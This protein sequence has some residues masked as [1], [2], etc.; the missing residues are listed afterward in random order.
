MTAAL[1]MIASAAAAQEIVPGVSVDGFK[2]ERNGNY[3]AVDMTLDLSGLKVRRNRAVLLTPCVINPDDSLHLKSVGVYGRRRYYYYVRNFGEEM[4]S[5]ADE[6][7]YRKRDMPSTLEYHDIV[8]YEGWMDGAELQLHRYLYGCCNEILDVETGRLG[9][10]VAFVPE[11]LY[12]TP[13]AEV[14]ARTLEGSAYVDFVVD[15]TDIRPDYHD[16]EAELGR[17]RA[18]I[19]SVH[20]DGDI[21]I[22]N[23]WLKGYAS[24]ESPYKHNSDLARGR[25]EAVKRHVQDLCDIPGEKITTEY[26]PE[27]WE[28][29]RRFVEQSGLEHRD[30]ILELIDTDMDPDAKEAQ[31]RRAYPAEYR[32]LLQEC[33]PYLR[34]TDYRV[35]YTVRGY[36]DVDEIRRILYTEPQKLNLNEMYLVA[37]TLEP[38]SDEFVEVFQI[39]VRMY[40]EDATANLNAANVEMRHGEYAAAERNLAKA[41]D[42]AEAEYARGVWCYLTDDREAARGH[43]E[44]AARAGIEQASRLLREME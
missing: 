44:T 43:L 5:G 3:M 23:I 26:E 13:R 22:D 10:Y 12:V 30:G 38:G 29:L 21:T 17:I 16:N 34:R 14:K 37:Q 41:G 2:A 7:T 9:T 20:G 1:C 35:N 36:S 28:G 40:P 19:N 4:I 18:T 39:A 11:F 8:P 42:S 33:Y 25:V 15:R 27:N 32:F 24:P 6:M 31:L